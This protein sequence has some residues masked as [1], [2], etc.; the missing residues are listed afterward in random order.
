MSST[1][2]SVQGS[3]CIG[4]FGLIIA[5]V[6]STINRDTGIRLESAILFHSMYSLN[7]IA[8]LTCT[9]SLGDFIA[10]KLIDPKFTTKPKK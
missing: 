7:G 5:L 3:F 4:G 1:S 8:A 2:S 9:L 10:L 6:N